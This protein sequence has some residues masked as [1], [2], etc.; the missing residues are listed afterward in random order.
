[1][2][3]LVFFAAALAPADA[4]VKLDDAKRFGTLD[5]AALK[6]K[7]QMADYFSCY[8]G[9]LWMNSPSRRRVDLVEVKSRQFDVFCAYREL[10]RATDPNFDDESKLF[11]LRV[12]RRLIGEANYRAG[13]IP[14]PCPPE[15]ERAF[16]AWLDKMRAAGLDTP[17]AIRAHHQ[18]E[19]ERR[20][21]LQKQQREGR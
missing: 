9:D 16:A 20:L 15:Y 10:D 2:T 21:A 13:F 8:L 17:D 14:P 3:A 11:G 19:R 7:W 12:L 1:M 18:R 4:P 6:Q 5:R